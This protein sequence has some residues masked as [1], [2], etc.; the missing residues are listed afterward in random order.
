[1]AN[2]KA[3]ICNQLRLAFTTQT[4]IAVSGTYDGAAGELTFV[5]ADDSISRTFKYTNKDPQQFRDLLLDVGGLIVQQ[6]N[7]R[8]TESELVAFMNQVTE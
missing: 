5:W 8:Y 4:V 3:S 7:T 6:Y 2:I 1:M